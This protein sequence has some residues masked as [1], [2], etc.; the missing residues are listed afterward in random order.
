M[1][2][3]IFGWSPESEIETSVKIDETE[4]KTKA[5][6]LAI[7]T[8]PYSVTGTISLQKY[9]DNLEVITERFVKIIK[10]EK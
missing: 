1:P 2:L 5:L 6:Y 9:C 4:L 10:G 3:R 7:T 8:Y